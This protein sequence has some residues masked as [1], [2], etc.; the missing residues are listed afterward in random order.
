MTL[1]YDV[2]CFVNVLWMFLRHIINNV[3][4]NMI[5]HWFNNALKIFNR[6]VQWPILVCVF[7]SI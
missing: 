2:T 3:L 5:K 6:N 4:I 1:L 7:A